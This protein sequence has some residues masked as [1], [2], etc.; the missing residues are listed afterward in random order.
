MSAEYIIEISNLKRE[1][2]EL[3]K[4]F[5][6]LKREFIELKEQNV[7]YLRV[8]VK[9]SWGYLVTYYRF[10]D[11]SR[12]KHISIKYLLSNRGINYNIFP[13]DEQNKKSI[14]EEVKNS[15][16][17]NQVQL[18]NHKDLKVYISKFTTDYD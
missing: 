4:E 13:E 8:E 18:K 3:H 15:I 1:L 9:P 11:N 12:T 16:P 17:T 6:E 7:Y 5:T 2:E 14:L 10:I